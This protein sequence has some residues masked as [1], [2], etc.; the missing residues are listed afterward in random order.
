VRP[1][2]DGTDLPLAT[3]HDAA[4]LDL[5]GVLYVGPQAVDG[6]PEAVTAMRAAGMRVA[7]VTNNAART[8]ETVAAHLTEL[9]IAAG[10][11]DVVTSAQAAATLVAAAVPPGSAVLVVG[12]EGLD[13]AVE[14][15]GLRPVR[16]A[17]EDPAAVVQGFAPEVGWRLLAEGTYA[18]RAG[19]PWIASNLDS[20]V[21]TPQGLAPG[22]GALV[23]VITA[24]TGARP[25]AA[26][27]PET[28]L[29]DEA[30]RRTDARTPLVVGDRL[31][32]DIEGANRAGV[33]S[34]L[35]LTGV[36]TAADLLL[37][38]EALRPTYVCRDLRSGLLERHPG[39]DRADGWSCGGWSC[40]ARDGALDL[41]GDGDALDGL[42]AA[43]AASWHDGPATPE[44]AARIAARLGL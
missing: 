26:G 1:L 22:N 14:E 6:A 13:V 36:A 16:T 42:R 30:V 15:R 21:P 31:D 19:V 35:V 12:G 20:T 33:P 7:F 18:V 23:G 29:H 34:L 43:A 27:K 3:R 11:Q 17:A 2:V 9:G 38:G 4:L 24:A 25:V 5:D 39:V 44:A 28:P 32:T 40:V 41:T 8:P 10:P 37:A